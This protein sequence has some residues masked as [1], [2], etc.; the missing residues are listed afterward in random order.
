[1]DL[2]AT[3]RR[4]PM[5]MREIVGLPLK[6]AHERGRRVLVFF[7]ELQRAVDYTDGH[8]VLTDIRDI[9]SAAQGQ[10]VVLVD[11]SDERS[12]DQLLADPYNFGKLVGRSPL[13]DIIPAYLW[14]DPLTAR[15]AEIGKDLADEQL[16]EI[17]TFGE[18]RP[19]DTM[20]AAR[21][22]ALTAAQHRDAPVSDFDVA[23]GLDLAR[24]HLR[25]DDV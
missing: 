19:Y 24:Q 8:D 4:G 15:F 12:I 18:G 17:I 6:V 23:T 13:P 3:G 10:S 22:T 1:M 21:Y 9:Y 5:A 14:R 2:G 7:D 25:D 20:A 16:D 11:G